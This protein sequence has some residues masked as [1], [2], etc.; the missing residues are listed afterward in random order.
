M[1]EDE[2][3]LPEV[4]EA[5]V[6]GL[7]AG[8]KE[9]HTRTTKQVVTNMEKG[10]DALGNAWEPLKPETIRQSTKSVPL[11]DSGDMRRDILASSEVDTSRLIGLIGTSKEYGVYHE[12]GAP[13][14]GIPRRPFLA[15]AARYAE[16]HAEKVIG[17]EID[18]RLDGA[19]L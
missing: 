11:V 19:M 7:G 18:S 17:T 10:Q 6:E 1:V 12:L 4:R 14:A 16:R 13:E 5:L 2:N 3:N 8:L 9:L 15:P